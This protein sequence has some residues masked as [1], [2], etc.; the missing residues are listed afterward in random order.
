MASLD[1]ATLASILVGKD[2]NRPPDVETQFLRGEEI[3]T[4]RQMLLDT[5]GEQ[6]D[7]GKALQAGDGTALGAALSQ[8]EPPL[9]SNTEIIR[10]AQDLLRRAAPGG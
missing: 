2:P 4:L 10:M 5:Y 1:L 9:D 8:A 3:A 6:S 7:I